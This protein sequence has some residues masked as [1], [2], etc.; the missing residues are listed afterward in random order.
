[1]S[2]LVSGYEMH[3]AITC[4]DFDE[5]TAYTEKMCVLTL[6]CAL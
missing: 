1:M 2:C 3:F 6:N 5:I 4:V